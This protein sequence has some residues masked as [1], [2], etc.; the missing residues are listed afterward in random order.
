MIGIFKTKLRRA[1]N[2]K[3]K[4]LGHTKGGVTVIL[5]LVPPDDKK[6]NQ[7]GNSCSVLSRQ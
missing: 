1:V 7:N 4:N 3:A 2:P 6:I 5:C